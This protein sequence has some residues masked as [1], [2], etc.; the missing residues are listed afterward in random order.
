M[1]AGRLILGAAVAT[2]VAWTHGPA[3]AV[4]SP[5]RTIASV[6]ASAPSSMILAQSAPPSDRLRGVEPAGAAEKKQR[7]TVPAGPDGAERGP[8]G[9]RGQDIPVERFIE[10]AEDIEPD[11]PRPFARS[12]RPTARRRP[13]RFGRTASAWS[14]W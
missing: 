4:S 9:R 10:V 14:G 3:H 6:L 13:R 7:P 2:A 1:D 11:G 8:G 5:E 12:S